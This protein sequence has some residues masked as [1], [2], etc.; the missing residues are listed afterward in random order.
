MLGAVSNANDVNKQKTAMMLDGTSEMS[1]EATATSHKL[2]TQ[3]RVQVVVVCKGR[4][5]YPSAG[6]DRLRTWLVLSFARCS[7]C[8]VDEY[9]VKGLNHHSG[10]GAG[11]ILPSAF[12]PNCLPRLV[13]SSPFSKMEFLF[14]VCQVLAQYYARA[15]T[16]GSELAL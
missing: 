10:T 1:P 9:F 15:S 14:G 5:D 11:L 16:A 7:L 8:T 2:S 6:R 4:H 13:P 3:A 12:T